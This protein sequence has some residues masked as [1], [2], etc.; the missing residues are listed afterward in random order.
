VGYKWDVN[1]SLKWGLA[2]RTIEDSYQ[3]TLLEMNIKLNANADVS[4]YFL[5]NTPLGWA[6][7]IATVTPFDLDLLSIGL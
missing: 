7:L 2:D 6:S 3:A 4:A 5:Y 1:T